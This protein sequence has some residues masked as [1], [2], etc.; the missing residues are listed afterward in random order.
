[1][2]EKDYEGATGRNFRQQARNRSQ[3]LW[4]VFEVASMSAK[5]KRRCDVAACFLEQSEGS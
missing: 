2:D 4:Q 5:Q 3:L 1:M